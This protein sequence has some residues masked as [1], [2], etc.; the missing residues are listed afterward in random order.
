MLIINSVTIARAT[1]T[2]ETS[3]LELPSPPI[4]LEGHW[5]S[6]CELSKISEMRI[7]NN[8][9]YLR[10]AFYKDPHCRELLF[11]IETEGTLSYPPINDGT[12][13]QGLPVDYTYQSIQLTA[14]NSEAAK[15]FQNVELCGHTQWKP[16]IAL[17]VT[18]RL[19]RFF[20]GAR[21]IQIPKRNQQR[22]GI[23]SITEP[24]LY[25][26]QNNAIEDS[27]S[28]ARRPTVLMSKPFG[29]R[30]ESQSTSPE[31]SKEISK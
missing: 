29:Q 25:F 4:T 15:D 17:N 27:S 20:E 28:P 11:S 31:I 14:L 16:L 13:T 24:W 19:C 30:L 10:E 12:N 18:G 1:F 5:W 23:Y 7:T 6:G 21:P 9:S 22:F 2:T 8:H 3:S 26:G